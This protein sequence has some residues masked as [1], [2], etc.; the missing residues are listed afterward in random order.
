M[1]NQVE[2][3]KHRPEH[4]PFFR[5]AWIELSMGNLAHNF[6]EIQQT[7]GGKRMICMVKANAYGHGAREIAPQ[8][9]KLGAD[10]FGVVSVGE[11]REL[12]EAGITQDILIVNYVPPFAIEEAVKLDATIT[13]RDKG[14]LQAVNVAAKKQ[15]KTAKVQVHIDTGMHREGVWPPEAGVEL[16][17][18][19]Q[20]YENVELDGIYT[21]FATADE[22]DLSFSRQQLAL[23]NRCLDDIEAGEITL[24]RF[25][26]AANSGAVLQLPETHRDAGRFTAVRPG[27]VLYGLSAGDGFAYPFTPK[28]VLSLKARLISVKDITADDSVGYA[29]TWRAERN[30]RVGLITLGYADGF[31]RSF[32]NTGHVLIHGYRVPVVGRV[33]MDQTILDLTDFPDIQLDEEVVVIGQQGNEQIRLEDWAQATGTIVNDVVTRLNATRLPRVIVNEVSYGI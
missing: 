6:H 16:V 26:H 10:A 33:S 12:R 27:I 28:P 24:P 2:A 8:L 31:A 23:F 7:V 15:H 4:E 17:A 19:I 13:L 20:Q 29:R 30:S 32:S 3:L 18:L 1:P 9:E 21:H 14:V 25:I 5:P 11:A 22:V